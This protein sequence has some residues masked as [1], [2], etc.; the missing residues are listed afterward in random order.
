MPLLPRYHNIVRERGVE[1]QSVQW[2]I[3]AENLTLATPSDQVLFEAKVLLTE[4]LGAFTNTLIKL[5]ND[6]VMVSIPEPHRPKKGEVLSFAFTSSHNY[7]FD[8]KT[9]I[10]V[11][12]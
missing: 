7:L 9:G 4:P 10:A 6:E 1:G 12:D 2:G 3:R 11:T 5:G 8:L